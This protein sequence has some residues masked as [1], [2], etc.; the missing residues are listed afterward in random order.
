[1][2]INTSGTSEREREMEKGNRQ[3][4]C[5]KRFCKVIYCVT[6][7]HL[8]LIVVL[9]ELNCTV[10][11]RALYESITNGS[12]PQLLRKSVIAK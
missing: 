11:C 6:K 5:L 2:L 10:Q 7:T 8:L 12:A 9:N 3:N 4:L 1:M